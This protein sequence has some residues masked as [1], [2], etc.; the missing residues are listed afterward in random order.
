MIM[1]TIIPFIS[2]KR[3]LKYG[4]PDKQ[5]TFNLYIFNVRLCE[6]MYPGLSQFEIVLRNKIDMVFSRYMGENWIFDFVLNDEKLVDEKHISDRNELIDSLTFAFWSRLFMAH[7]CAAIWDK[8]PTALQEIFECR[9]NFVS[10]PR[11]AFEIDQIRK[12]R[13]RFSHNGSLLLCSKRQMPCHKIHNLIYR[14]I[15][16]MGANTVLNQI[17]KIDRFNEV[18]TDGKKAG[19]ITCKI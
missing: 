1:D 8:Y 16:E 19:F 14:M 17:K 3:L 6:C 2:E 18:F 4:S 7:N 10:L 13:N 11:I 9:R 15:K 12:Y 5:R